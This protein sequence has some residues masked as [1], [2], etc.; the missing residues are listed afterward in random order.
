MFIQSG[1]RK[2]AKING[3]KMVYRISDSIVI[4]TITK[5]IVRS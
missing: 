5:S 1:N 4:I 3:N 2:Y